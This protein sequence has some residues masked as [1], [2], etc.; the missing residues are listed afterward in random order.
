MSRPFDLWVDY[1]V[2]M[3]GLLALLCLHQS[4]QISTPPESVN[5][6]KFYA[7]FIDADGY[8]IV[9]S[10]NVNDYAL[11]EAAYLVRMLLAKR[12]DVRDAMIKSGSRMCIIAHN[13]F[14]T[15]LPEFAWLG[16]QPMKEFPT[17]SGKDFW[18]A[19]ARGTGGSET[20]PYCS[21]A[22]EN[23]LGYQGDPY[24]TECIL[25]HEFAHS[26][27][28]RGMNAIDP[29]FDKRVRA[30]YDDALSRGLWK[31]KYASVSP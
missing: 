19:R 13:E 6:S 21:S 9:A 5:K 26:I 4:P 18:D 22:E 28:L 31:G 2:I 10:S 8:P 16:K 20:D 15:D 3:I 24:S 12:P 7:K 11:K 29:T 14:T 1:T 30:A 23:I 17:I 27:H 25:I